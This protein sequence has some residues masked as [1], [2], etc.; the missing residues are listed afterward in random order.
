V[1][2]VEER[3]LV[4][5]LAFDRPPRAV[6]CLG[7]HADDIEIGAAAAIAHIAAQ[8]PDCSFLFAVATGDEIRTAEAEASAAKL[9]GD[10]VSVEVAGF[11][12]GLLPYEEPAAVKRFFRSAFEE[13]ESDVVFCPT[14]SDRHQDHA[15]IGTL[16]H[17]IM[18]D[19]LILQYE[20][21]KSDGDLTR[22]SVYV[23]LTADE[24]QAKLEHLEGNF[25]SQQSK[26]WYDRE[27]LQALI[28]LRGVECHAP[29]GYAEAFHADRIVIR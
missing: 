27:A 5:G 24:V 4:I 28:R 1:G 2:V 19:Q 23:P 11:A 29:E 10:R 14:L 26:P 21:H 25:A 6:A 16:A 3:R 12:D 7:A 15:F 18:R 20:I 22:P 17:Q 9:L 13:F 8:Y